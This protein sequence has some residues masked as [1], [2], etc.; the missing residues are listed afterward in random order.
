M[1]RPLVIGA[2]RLP[3]NLLLAPMAGITDLPVRL[4]A[5][6]YGAVLCFTEMVSVNG[7]LRE[8][9]RS[10]ELLRSAPEDRPL[11][12]QIFGEEPETLGEGAELVAPYGD[13]VDINMGCPVRKVVG[14]GAGSALLRKPLK[15]AAIIRSARRRI[16]LPLTVKIR[17]GWQAGE[18]NYREIAAIAES[19]GCDA[20]TLHPRIRSR[21]FSGRAAWEQI[22][23][24]KARLSIPVIGSGDLFT[25]QD[26]AT[27]LTETGCDGVMLARGAMGNPWL[28]RDTLR[29]LLGE[30]VMPPSPSERLAVSRSHFEQFAR[31]SGERIAVRE[32][33]KHLSW[34]AK[35]LPG[36]AAFRA[37]INRIDDKERFIGCIEDFFGQ[38]QSDGDR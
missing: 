1:L 21:M 12:I 6:G 4:L 23:E 9:H 19:E 29:F 32:M 35:G 8:G 24:V 37:E 16:T 31:I 36:A 10:F 13:L 18:E 38:E 14:S 20:V 5:R 33:R 17:S 15:V 3:G 26:V 11:G 27:M 30:P 7:L 2:L 28:F 34:Y 25:P 22:A